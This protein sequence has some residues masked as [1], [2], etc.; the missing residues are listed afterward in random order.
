MSAHRDYEAA[1]AAN[2]W[3]GGPLR[4]LFAVLDKAAAAKPGVTQWFVLRSGAFVSLKYRGNR[5][6]EMRIRRLEAFKTERG[7]DLWSKE[8]RTFVDEF[9]VA[10]WTRLADP[11]EKGGVGVI[12]VEPHSNSSPHVHCAWEGCDQVVML[13]YAFT[14]CHCNQHAFEQGRVTAAEN[15]ARRAAEQ[16]S[17]I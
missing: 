11:A 13:E 8:V 14:H 6:R 9:A 16:Q 17:V 10:H 2:R 5:T 4:P 3:T 15:A 1:P 7:P 12:L